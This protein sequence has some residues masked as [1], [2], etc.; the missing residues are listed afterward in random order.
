MLPSP[1]EIAYFME[2]ANTM[3]VTR[4]AERLGISQ[5]SLSLALQRLES[6]IGTPLFLRS[7]RGVSLTQAGR[8]FLAHAR[9]LLDSWDGIK[10]KTL[11]S[12]SEVQGLC[13]IG[14]H[15]S[16]ALHSVS[17]FLPGLVEKHP[18][19]EIRFHHGL[20]RKITENVI[21][22]KTDIGLVVNPVRH[23]DLVIVP[24]CRDVVTLWTAPQEAAAGDVLICDPELVQSQSI[25]KQFK[26]R[27]IAFNR[28][29]VS[30]NLELIA[31]LTAAGCG[32]G[33]LP[34]QVAARAKTEI[35][36]VA[37]APVFHDEHC[38]VYRVENKNV[39]SIR[40]IGNAIRDFFETTRVSQ[41]AASCHPAAKNK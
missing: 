21:S 35:R 5:P 36:P 40:I 1:A 11:S 10:A 20:S 6:S 19:L 12:E 13:T 37:R 25:M 41:D 26:K 2:T 24:L 4:A 7:R 38:L 28:M 16:V 18:G 39:K 33:I 17:G 32:T 14:V 29:I 8:Q 30:E 23:P 3:N 22:L 27:R 31:D 15:P 34:A 9:T